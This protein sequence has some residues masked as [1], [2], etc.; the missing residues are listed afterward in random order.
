MQLATCACRGWWMNRHSLVDAST[1]AS[2]P[3]QF[4]RR[5]PLPRPSTH[6][7]IL[8][9]RRGLRCPPHPN[10]RQT[11]CSIRFLI[12]QRPSSNTRLSLFLPSRKRP[13]FARR[14]ASTTTT[15][16][17]NGQWPPK[18]TLSI[19]LLPLSRPAS[20]RHASWRTLCSRKFFLPF[21]SF[22]FSFLILQGMP[23]FTSLAT[24]PSFV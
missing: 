4:F 22:A 9:P 7:S 8:H 16:M 18:I 10:P 17:S 6:P 20:H 19:E 15:T 3:L 24:V 23:V 12:H 21:F 11:P 14:P 2:L 5:L 13:A 1:S